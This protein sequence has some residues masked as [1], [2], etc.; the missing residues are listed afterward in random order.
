MI[1]YIEKITVP[2]YDTDAS[3]LLK[4]GNNF[5]SLEDLSNIVL[6]NIEDIGD[7]RLCDVA[8]ITAIDNADDSYAK[9]DGKDGII[10]ACYCWIMDLFV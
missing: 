2:C 6:T 4:V 8:N 7:V 1:K 5:E 3:W 9:L 10:S